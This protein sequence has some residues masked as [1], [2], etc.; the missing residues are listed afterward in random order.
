METSGFHEVDRRAQYPAWRR[1]GVGLLAT[2]VA[3][4]LSLMLPE[5]T[6]ETAFL[7]FL[8]AVAFSA[9]YGGV[10]PAVL[11]TI[12]G[13]GLGDY[14]FVQ[15]RYQWTI[16]A[17]GGLMRLVVFGSTSLGIILIRE[18]RGRAEDR[19]REQ[20]ARLSVTLTSIAD[21][22]I[23]TDPLGLV[24]F[25]NPVAERLTGWPAVQAQGRNLGAVFQ[26]IDE[27][28]RA[29]IASPVATALQLPPA[30]LSP[31][32]CLLIARD[33]SERPID[34]S[35]A[36]MRAPAGDLLGVVL[37]FRDVSERH[38]ADAE[39]TRLLAEAQRA[40]AVRD[41]FLTIASHELKTPL[42]GLM[43][44]AQLLQRRLGR[45]GRL[46]EA[47]ARALRTLLDQGNRLN[48]MVGS[49]LDVSRIENGQ[50]RI[51]P[52]RLDLVILLRRIVAEVQPTLTDHTL[53]LNTCGAPLW[54]WGDALRL[55]QVFQ[56]LIANAVKYSPAGGP[57]EIHTGAQG[58]EVAVSVCDAGIGIPAESLPH[59]F[60]RFYRA[61]NTAGPQGISGIGVGLYV[62]R[63]IVDLHHGTIRVETEEGAGSRFTVCLPR[64]E[65]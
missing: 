42:T 27:T 36:P 65:A 32:G 39:R 10:G 23:A 37:V 16:L 59:L 40:L 7:L 19:L 57:V 22:V 24:T 28:T 26:V 2:S 62:V 53:V 64:L 54:V 56:N 63:Q 18:S 3:F 21:A 34:S 47:N 44:S 58:P 9:W 17:A 33:G 50:L 5:A 8:A 6:D 15:P 11:A 29:P 55:E 14:F 61:P 20:T 52:A 49:L 25:M 41:Q 60:Q 38:A 1:Y 51:D 43:G 12:L 46:G 13:A 35:A 45:D 31:D 48:R 30:P 4:V